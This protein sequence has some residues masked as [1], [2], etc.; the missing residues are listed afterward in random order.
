M[1]MPGAGKRFADVVV[2]K[3]SGK[4][5]DMAP[6][7]PDD[8]PDDDDDEPGE[9]GRVIIS[10]MRKGDSEAVEEAI[11]AIFEDCMKERDGA[12]K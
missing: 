1:A 3:L 8:E 5:G 6:P 10:A 2:A 7:A 9:Q 4:P 11:R 12:G